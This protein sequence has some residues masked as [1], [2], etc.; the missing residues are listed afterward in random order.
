M[1]STNEKGKPPLD[2]SKLSKSEFNRE[3]QRGFDDFKHGQTF[4]AQGIEKELKIQ[5]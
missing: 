4:V 5:N 2:L 1:T 3:I